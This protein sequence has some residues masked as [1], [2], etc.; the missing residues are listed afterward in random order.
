[1]FFKT[2]FYNRVIAFIWI[3]MV[4]GNYLFLPEIA[5]QKAISPKRTAISAMRCARN[6]STIRHCRPIELRPGFAD[7]WNN[8]GTTLRDLKQPEEA[9]TIYRKA[10]RCG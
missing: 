5:S 6:N 3:K 8:L 1:M 9:E 7:A 4:F 10:L 2:A